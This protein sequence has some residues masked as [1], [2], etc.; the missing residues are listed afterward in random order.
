MTSQRESAPPIDLESLCGPGSWPRVLVCD[1]EP[2]IRQLARS[3]FEEW[4]L[5]TE[6]AADGREALEKVQEEV[7][8]LILLDAKMPH[9]DGFETLRRLRDMP[10]CADV[11]V[12]MITSPGDSSSIDR[13][14]A[15]RATDFV[16]KPINW[17]ILRYRVIYML[18]LRRL[19]E[20]LE[21]SRKRLAD[22]QRLSRL[23]HWQWERRSGLVRCSEEMFRVF[24]LGGKEGWCDPADL[25]SRLD[26]RDRKL[27]ERRLRLA[28]TGREV[29]DTDI[30]VRATA[31]EELSVRCRAERTFSA[32]GRPTGLAGTALDITEAR[33]LE[34]ERRLLSEAI[35]QSPAAVIITDPTGEIR[36]VNR[37]F[38]EMTGYREAEVLGRPTSILPS[39]RMSEELRRDLWRAVRNKQEWRGE[40]QNQRRDGG[41][42]WVTESVSP[43]VEEGAISHLVW[44]ME[45]IT[46]RKGYEERLVR[47]A[48]Y[49]DLTGLPNRLLALDRLGQALAA[50]QRRGEPVA[51]LFLDLDDFRSIND[52]RGHGLGDELLC[53]VARRLQTVVRAGDTLARTGGDEFLLVARARAGAESAARQAADC[54]EIVGRVAELQGG[55]VFVN[56]SIGIAMAPDDGIDPHILL[57]NAEAA[58]YRAKERSGSSFDFFSPAMNQKACA[59]LEIAVALR[60]ALEGGELDLEYQPIV[61][62]DSLDIIA[63]E[64]LLRWNSAS[65]GR[66]GPDQFIP[67]AE[68]TGLI[69]PIGEWVVKTA[70]LEARRWELETGRR[71]RVAVN[72]SPRQVNGEDIVGVVRRALEESGLAPELLELEITER[73]LVEEGPRAEETLRQLRE[74]GVRLALDDFGTGQSSLGNLRRMPM[75]VVKIDRTFLAA[76]EEADRGLLSAILEMARALRLEVVVE[77]V[78]T[79]DQ[80]DLLRELRG[81][82]AQGYHFSRPQVADR[83]LASLR[84]GE[85]TLPPPGGAAVM[86]ELR[87]TASGAGR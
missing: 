41:G 14:F 11:P 87:R 81:D 57:R 78:E 68:D 9:L 42:F 28:L 6:E 1:D 67:V 52:S 73:L 75:D 19:L 58:M 72:V 55:E 70:C 48:N 5:L 18:R 29:P 54:L 3:F 13:A 43:I 15:L 51:V 26:P 38:E 45:D 46:V 30:R 79:A 2:A 24:G 8:D 16:S 37:R 62:V 22:A 21:D 65:L 77:G 63:A 50:T 25:L 12:V 53:E 23:G 84:S 47:Q 17:V 61:D 4:G 35:E 83:F 74:L 71:I 33:R 85:W 7:P 80:L 56:A 34:A 69:V 20:Q 64:G 60:K 76:M 82:L 66:V 39:D 44:S 49:D 59:R 32:D 86:A 10:G 27:A 40:V 31:G 36:Y